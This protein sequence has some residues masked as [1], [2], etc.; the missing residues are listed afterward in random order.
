ME[1]LQSQLAMISFQF[2]LSLWEKW[3]GFAALELY[4]VCPFLEDRQGGNERRKWKAPRT[5]VSREGLTLRT[6]RWRSWV[7]V[8]HQ[9]LRRL[10][11]WL[12]ADALDRKPTSYYVCSKLCYMPVR[13][14]SRHSRSNAESEANSSCP[15][16]SFLEIGYSDN[17]ANPWGF[18][19]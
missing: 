13:C 2:L 6:P 19:K 16:D 15:L 17:P 10:V 1:T 11:D 18:W 3:T 12:L 14:A 5:C 4:C 9:W 7:V 8:L